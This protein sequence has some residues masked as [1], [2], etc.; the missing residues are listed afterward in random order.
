MLLGLE[1]R[2]LSSGAVWG[3]RGVV[4]PGQSGFQPGNVAQ[5]HG[6][7][8]PQVGYYG[9]DGRYYRDGRRSGRRGYVREDRRPS[10]NYGGYYVYENPYARPRGYRSRG[11]GYGY[12]PEQYWLERREQEFRA[13]NSQRSH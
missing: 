5:R 4:A 7:W 8:S 11:Y 3:S 1:D 12:S 2:L 9:A 13:Y 10:R 6:G